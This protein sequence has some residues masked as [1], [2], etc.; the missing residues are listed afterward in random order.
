MPSKQKAKG[1]SWERDVAKFLSELYNESF[2]RAPGSGA[3]IGGKNTFRKNILDESQVKSFKG[4]IVPGESF[5]KFNCE[6]KFYADFPFHHFLTMTK[7]NQLEEWLGQL[8]EVSDDND[9]NILIFKINRKG[10]F[11]AVEEIH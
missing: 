4:D 6:C 10:A 8:L 5:A 1:S 7:V 11:V 3:Y 9:F 2:I